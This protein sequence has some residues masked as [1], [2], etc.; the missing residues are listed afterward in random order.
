MLTHPLLHVVICLE[1]TLWDERLG[2]VKILGSLW[3][4]KREQPTSEPGGKYVD[5]EVHPPN[6]TVYGRQRGVAKLR[7]RVSLM[8]GCKIW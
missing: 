2:S 7:R 4:W 5:L 3:S 6:G 8:V 1:P